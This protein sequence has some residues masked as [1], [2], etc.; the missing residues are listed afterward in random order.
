MGSIGLRWS[1]LFILSQLKPV[2][3]LS[4]ER[5]NDTDGFGL[6]ETYRLL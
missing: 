3:R 6:V 4:K 2:A 5:R 1:M